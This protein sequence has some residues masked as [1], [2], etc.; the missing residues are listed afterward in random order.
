MDKRLLVVDDNLEIQKLLTM[1]LGRLGFEVDTA[2]DG[3]EALSKLL[4]KEFTAVISDIDMPGID[5][6][7][8]CQ[9]VKKSSPE[10]KVIMMT[11][12][13]SPEIFSTCLERGADYCFFKPFKSLAALSSALT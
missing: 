10:T 7:T 2:Q 8:L 1:Y 13:R 5:G 3:E 9:S 11:G 4:A 12:S 6:L